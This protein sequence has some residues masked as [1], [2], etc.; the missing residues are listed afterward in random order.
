M[1]GKPSVGGDRRACHVKAVMPVTG[2]SL[3]LRRA[4][5]L[6]AKLPFPSP[7]VPEV[8]YALERTNNML[9]RFWWYR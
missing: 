3:L 9:R 2:G 6:N 7:M 5:N 1:D 4:Q 8:G